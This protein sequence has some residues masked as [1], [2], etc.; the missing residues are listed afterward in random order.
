MPKE[1]HIEGIDP[2][3]AVDWGLPESENPVRNT[4][5]RYLI[6]L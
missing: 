5:H 2:K 6:Q 1:K 4:V 3:I